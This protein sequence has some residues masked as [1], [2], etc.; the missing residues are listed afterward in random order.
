MSVN[1]NTVYT[2]V[3]A[4]INKEQR[5]YITPQEFNL[6]ANQAQL[7]IFEQYFYDL[8][9]FM[10]LPGNDTGHADMISLLQEKIA[11]FQTSKSGAPD[12]A[13]ASG[14]ITLAT[15]DIYRLSAVYVSNIEADRFSKKEAK[16]I[17]LSPLSVPTTDRPMYYIENSGFYIYTSGSLLGSVD[18]VDIHYIKAP[19]TVEWGY[20]SN[21]NLYNASTSNNFDLHESEETELVLKIIE[22]AGI[23]LK[24]PSLYQIGNQMDTQ[25]VQQEK[26]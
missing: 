10:R 20:N 7:E 21:N 6:F 25:K 15:D 5:G 23:A 12:L 9:Q 13:I 26:V 4:I 2:R 17:L 14:R 11:L 1:V 8:N 3:L 16:N 18:N 22:L 19:S 24:D